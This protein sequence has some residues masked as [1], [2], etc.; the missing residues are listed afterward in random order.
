MRRSLLALL[1]LLC[2]TLLGF[3]PPS[4]VESDDVRLPVG[5][6]QLG[7][8]ALARLP[9]QTSR[10]SLIMDLATGGVVFQRNANARLAPASITKIMTAIVVLEHAD[11]QEKVTALQEDM[12]EGSSMGLRPGDTLTVGQLLWGMLLPSGN[13]AAY[14]LARHV[15]RG[16]QA[17]FAQMMNDKAREMGLQDTQFAN[18][19]GLDNP[20]HFSSAY[21]LAQ[22]SRYALRNPVFA[23]IVA[24]PEFT[25]QASRTFKLT[26]VNSLLFMTSAVPGVNG[27]KTG[28]TEQAGESMVA[29]VDREGHKVLVVVLG[30]PD[31]AVAATALIN[32]AYGYFSWVSL[33]LP[34]SLRGSPRGQLAPAFRAEVMV[35]RWQSS[36]VNYSVQVGVIPQEGT[37]SGPVGVLT[38]SLA[39]QE[40]SRLP[41]Y[42]QQR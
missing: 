16:S 41:L 36:Y 25:A 27:V 4:L 13:D 38:Y 14:A 40:L 23:R 2:P 12:I 11:L 5:K 28:F 9:I 31:R 21:D 42:V 29:S 20:N 7:V 18:P 39:G 22:I 35:P 26:N 37:F 24:T 15:G 32:F 8:L 34:I 1:F 30:S 17:Q 3:G 10:A 19:H 6:P 33:P